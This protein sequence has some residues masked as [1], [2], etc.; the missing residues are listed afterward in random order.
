M[1]RK[2]AILS[3]F[4]LLVFLAAGCGSSTQKM[5]VV[6][7]SMIPALGKGIKVT[8]DKKAYEKS[9]PQRGD[10]IAFK[11]DSGNALIKRVIGLPGE[12]VEI[13]DKKVYI[14]GN[15][16]SEG[17]LYERDSTET[18]VN[19]SWVV[20]AKSVF[21]MGDNRASSKDSREFGSIPVKNIIGK[22]I[23]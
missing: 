19:A 21:V 2:T 10:I 5:T 12:T 8:V 1:I 17:Y 9:Q 22:V 3:L 16:L 13:K 23:S 4:F 15:E 11:D 18:V 14:G 6:G 7:T 20:P